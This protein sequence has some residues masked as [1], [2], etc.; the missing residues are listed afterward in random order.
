MKN[1]FLIPTDKPNVGS[2]VKYKDGVLGIIKELME[3]NHFKVDIP[4]EGISIE[5]NTTV[6]VFNLYIT[7][8]KEIEKGVETWYLDKFLNKPRNSGGA[9]Y[10]FEQDVIILS[11]DPNLIADDVQAIDDI[12]LEWFINNQSCD[13]V[14]I[15]CWETKGE[16]N[17]EYKIIIPKEESKNLDNPTT[18]IIREA[19]K[20]VSKDVRPPKLSSNNN[21]VEISKKTDEEHVIY[22]IEPVLNYQTTNT[23]EG[24]HSIV[25]G[26]GLT[27][28][29][30]YQLLVDRNGIKIDKI[31]TI[32]EHDLLYKVLKAIND[33]KI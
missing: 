21:L 9:E 3:N 32:E 6:K 29:K 18:N 26:N 16:W 7:S 4:L 14:G 15:E 31:M 19:M 27:S 2:L 10:V 12:F 28:T 1:I 13:F 33:F 23:A 22:N 30:P 24:N 11:T 17:L 8:S 25:I 20:I 5:N